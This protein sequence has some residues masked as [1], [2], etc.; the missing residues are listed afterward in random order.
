MTGLVRVQL[1]I[2]W[3]EVVDDLDELN[4]S[5]TISYLA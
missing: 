3:L 5:G 2:T 4:V 1:L